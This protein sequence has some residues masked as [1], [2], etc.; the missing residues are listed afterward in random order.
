MVTVSKSPSQILGAWSSG[1]FGGRGGAGGRGGRGGGG[2]SFLMCG[3]T[4]SVSGR[5]VVEV[6]GTGG[7]V[8]R[9][10]G[11]GRAG[12]CRPPS[13]GSGDSGGGSK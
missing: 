2:A 10:L 3:V 7:D 5:E 11:S 9:G 13:V 1:S 12:G 8:G 4:G 6:G